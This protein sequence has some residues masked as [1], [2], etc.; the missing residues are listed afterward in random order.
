MWSEK[1]MRCKDFWLK[2]WSLF[3]REIA[4]E[5]AFFYEVGDKKPTFRFAV[6]HLSICDTC[7]TE[8]RKTISRSSVSHV[9]S[10]ETWLFAMRNVKTEGLNEL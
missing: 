3:L 5:N 9:S 8:P 2:S 7:L 1:T 4:R 10:L 6:R